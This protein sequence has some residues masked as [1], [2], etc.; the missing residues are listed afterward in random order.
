MT[1]FLLT[2]EGVVVEEAEPCSEGDET[3]RVLR[4][5]SRGQSIRT[6]W[7]KTSSLI[8]ISDCVA[9]ITA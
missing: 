1:P 7:F 3:W 2:L 8:M 6:V 9:T 4:A 5:T